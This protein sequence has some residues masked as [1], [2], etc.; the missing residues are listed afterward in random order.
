MSDF[1]GSTPSIT[2]FDPVIPYQRKLIN[3]VR[4]KYSYNLGTHEILLSGSVGSA[5]SMVAAHL[6][7][8]HCLMYPR[9]RLLLG[10][11]SLPDVKATIYNKI[12]EHIELDLVE[13]RDYECTDTIGRIIFSNGSEIICKSWADKKYK[14]F[15]SLDLSAAIFEEV[16]EN[17]GDDINAYKEIKMRVGRLP[18]VPENW[19]ISNTN[20]GSPSSY[21]YKYFIDGQSKT[22]HVYYSLTHENPFL[23]D[24]YIEQLKQDMDPKEARRMLY[25]EWIDLT[26][27]VVY[28]NYLKERNYRDYPYKFNDLAPID[29]SFDFNIGDGKP[30]SACV[31]QYIGETFH[32]AKDF[33]VHG[34][35]TSDIMEEMAATGI[36][37]RPNLFRIFGDASGKS[38][39]TRSI[40][41]DY[42]IIKEFLSNYQKHNSNEKVRFESHV[43]LA[44]PAIRSRHNKANATFLNASGQVNFYCYNEAKVVD[45]GLRLTK[46]KKGG[47]YIEDDSQYY[48]HVTTAL[49]YWIHFMKTNFREKR[50]PYS[51]L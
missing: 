12:K 26:Q 48:Q 17:E 51:L 14:R 29:L 36:F 27:D 5:K 16:I 38:R 40:K 35:R 43:P 46:L 18:H 19:I 50:L 42:T 34:A 49:T 41:S 44:N 39:D 2:E 47:N 45:E 8:T 32:V 9:A 4:K 23:P 1:V 15:R 10:R 28:Y 13:G 37:D 11:R 25:G 3:S 24:K 21:W 30:M 33:V 31:G 7:V 6:G 20:P 22:R